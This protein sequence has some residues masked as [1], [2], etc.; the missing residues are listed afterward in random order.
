MKRSMNVIKNVAKLCFGPVLT[1]GLYHFDLFS[2][3]MQAINLFLNCHHIYGALTVVFILLSYGISVALLR[4]HR[5]M[6][7]S[8]ASVYHYHIS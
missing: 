1:Y 6:V 5:N 4:Y 3:F 7:L 2:D 8:K